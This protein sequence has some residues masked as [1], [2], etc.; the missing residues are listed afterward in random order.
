MLRCPVALFFFAGVL[1]GQTGTIHGVV[2][3]SI[4]AP[5][6]GV[7]VEATE[8]TGHGALTVGAMDGIVITHLAPSKAVE[9]D[10]AGKY[11]IKD[12]A[13]GTYSVKTERDT[14]SRTVKV[15]AG[16]EVSLDLVIPVTPT[17]SGRVLNQD[18]EPV[19]DALV[20]LVTAEIHN[21]ALRQL[22]I[23][24]KATGEDGSYSFDSGVEVNRRYYVLVDRPT[25]GEQ[26][27]TYYPSATRMDAAAAVLLHAGETNR[28]VDI[29]VATAPVYCVDGRMQ[30]DGKP[31]IADFAIFEVPLAGTRL[32]R[33]RG[34]TGEDG[35]YHVCGLPAGSYRL[36]ADAGSAEFVVAGS[37]VEHVDLSLDMAYPKLQI[38][39]DGDAN[40]SEFPKLNARAIASLRKIAP[41]MGVENPSDE[42]I[43]T[44][45]RRF[46]RPN[47]SDSQSANAYDSLRGDPNELA[48]LVGSLTPLAI[49]ANVILRGID[50]SFL[51]GIKDAMPAGEYS[52]DI[53]PPR[54]SYVKEVTFNG[55]KLSGGV[56]RLAPASSGTLHILMVRGVASLKV[57]VVDGDGKPVPNATVLVA[58]E[59]ATTVESLAR[60]ARHGQTDQSGEYVE[61]SLAP[62]KYR[63][64]AT[65]Q[66]IR[67]DVPDDLEKMLLVMFQAKDVELGAKAAMQLTV[68]PVPVF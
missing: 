48:N 53:H 59:S 16:T 38:E 37:D 23:G 61:A 60:L 14:A 35:K 46:S 33:L 7:T 24:P 4:G 51:G 1:T 30:S 25:G 22:A 55:L 49:P 62:G 63:V 27:P 41:L 65:P 43:Q 34:G 11:T 42:D 15:E 50:N 21:G 32:T 40:A 9:S 28:Q 57:S 6:A 56:L 3:D 5:A 26:V 47:P 19:V 8:V 17:I 44:L 12:L 13:P 31:A 18:K 20:W 54:D 58:P 64:L 36:S 29:K 39:W 67:W 2:K 66:N 45:A 10:E 68:A 52:V